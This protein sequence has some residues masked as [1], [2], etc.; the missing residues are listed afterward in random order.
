MPSLLSPL[1][2][3]L[4]DSAHY[5]ANSVPG[6]IFDTATGARY[7]AYY[8]GAVPANCIV[9][10]EGETA[11]AGNGWVGGGREVERRRL[12]PTAIQLVEALSV[13]PVCMPTRVQLSTHAQPVTRRATKTPTKPC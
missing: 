3:L 11:T 7:P 12:Q 1:L 5:A 10:V 2:P 4:Q 6:A 8:N 13:A 9:Q